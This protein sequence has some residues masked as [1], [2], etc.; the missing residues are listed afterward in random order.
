MTD[1]LTMEE[2]NTQHR[3]VLTDYPHSHEVM[4]IVKQIAL[5]ANEIQDFTPYIEAVPMLTEVDDL[6]NEDVKVL[7]DLTEE[8]PLPN[9]V[10]YCPMIYDYEHR[11]T[12]TINQNKFG[13]AFNINLPGV[14]RAFLLFVGP[15]SRTSWHVDNA[16]R[17]PCTPSQLYNVIFSIQIPSTD[18]NAVGVKINNTILNISDP[19]IFDSQVPHQG[20]NYTDKM[21][22]SVLLLINKDYFK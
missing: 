22:L 21:W 5:V 14:E 8:L 10:V 20:W 12:P 9:T 19:I 13:N 15:T 2:K 17:E 7:I 3:V 6:A 1:F 16:S 4:E 11:L 18:P